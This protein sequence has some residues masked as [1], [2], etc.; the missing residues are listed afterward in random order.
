MVPEVHV[1]LSPVEMLERL[2]AFDTDSSKSNLA[3]IAFVESYLAANGI[4]FVKAFNPEGDKAAI[5]ATVGPMRD[6]GVVLSG[7]TDVVP[8]AGQ[9]WTGDP[10]A[11][12]REGGR[13]YG[14]GACDMKGFDAVCLTALPALARLPL[15]APVHLLLSYDEETTC[16]GVMDI[17]GRFGVSLP[18]PRAV[19]VGEPSLMQ[20]ADAHKSVVTFHTTVTGFENHSSHPKRG[21]SAIT[22]AVRLI[23]EIGRIA[24]EFEALGDPTGRFDPPCTTLHVGEIRGGTARN[25]TARECWFHWEYR[26][27]PGLDNEAIPRRLEAYGRDTVLPELTAHGRPASIRTVNDVSVPGLAPDAGSAA[28][29]LA[30]ALTASNRTITVPYGSEA[31]RFQQAGIAT[32]ICGPGDIAQAHQPDEWILESE[33]AACEA[34]VRRL[35]ERLAG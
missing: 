28:E 10:F 13:L 33:L 30:L 27:V 17:I 21:V 14:R 32:V 11:L 31:G 26:G 5:L 22:G 25:I 8:V 15:S 6:G 23:T 34:F 20:V 9:I 7:H 18:R 24:D 2:V 4:A 3:L 1:Q 19:I 16:E 35:G 12:R 29:T